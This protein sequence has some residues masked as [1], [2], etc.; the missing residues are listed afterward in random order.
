MHENMALA[1]SLL[2]DGDA[3]EGAVVTKVKNVF[4]FVATME[5]QFRLEAIKQTT[6][7]T[8]AIDEELPDIYQ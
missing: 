1:K 7:L 3:D 4:D 2:Y 6:F 5:L 8:Y